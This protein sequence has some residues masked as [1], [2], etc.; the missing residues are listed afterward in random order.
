MNGGDALIKAGRSAR[1]QPPKTLIHIR[2]CSMEVWGVS[3]STNPVITDRFEQ[4]RL[5]TPEAGVSAA[6]LSAAVLP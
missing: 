2:S 5:V 6:T 3:F 4:I 1:V